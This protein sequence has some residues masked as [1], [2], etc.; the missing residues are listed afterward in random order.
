MARK[1]YGWIRNATIIEA[2]KVESRIVGGYIRCRTDKTGLYWIYLPRTYYKAVVGSLNAMTPLNMEA[3]EVCKSLR[4]KSCD[5]RLT[6]IAEDT[7]T[8]GRSSGMWDATIHLHMIA[9]ISDYR[10]GEGGHG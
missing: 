8:D 3:T 6:H 10:L 7:A 5:V 2:K 1:E 9:A 4:G